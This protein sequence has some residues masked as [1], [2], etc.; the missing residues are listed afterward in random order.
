[1]WRMRIPTGIED[2]VIRP[3]HMDDADALVRHANNRK[4]WRNLMDA[5]PHPYERKDARAWLA[6]ATDE[7]A[8]LNF[9]IATE[10][11]AIGG[12]GLKRLY[13]VAS[14]SM[15]IGYWL[16]EPF[17]GRGIATAAVRAFSTWAFEEEGLGIERLF[18]DIFAWNPAS[19]RV[20][21]KA[22][23]Q[24]EGRLRR[25]VFKDGEFTDLIVYGRLR[26]EG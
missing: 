13:D 5:F 1:M 3:W 20:L 8:R 21:E 11:E 2:I 19:G 9:A 10:Q 22:G 18:A 17:W 24:Q 12:I 4:V 6:R 7:E 15:E 16:G 26:G 25:H 23:F 14:K